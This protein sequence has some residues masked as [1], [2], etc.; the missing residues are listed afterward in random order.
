MKKALKNLGGT[1]ST[2]DRTCPEE[3]LLADY[4]G[5]RLVAADE[6]KIET[7][8][9]DCA[10]CRQTLVAAGE[11]A[12]IGLPDVPA[13]WIRDMTDQGRACFQEP[14]TSDLEAELSRLEE[15]YGLKAP[16]TGRGELPCIMVVDDDVNYLFS[17]SETLAPQYSVIACRSGREAIA[18]MSDRVHTV[19]LDIKMPGMS[20]LDVAT[21]MKKTYRKIP[22]VFNTGYPGEYPEAQIERDYDPF[23]YVTKDNSQ[24]LMLQIQRAVE[25]T[26]GVHA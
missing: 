6:A 1:G 26:Q 13:E 22:V 3:E 16:E 14:E 2:T 17:L 21:E 8:L 18:N 20:G 10:R 12:D 19:I 9:A 4:L 24:L 15:K 5:G 7:H 11:T 23:G 25:H